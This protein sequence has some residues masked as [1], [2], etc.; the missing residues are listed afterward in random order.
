M[1]S[2]RYIN[3]K[4]RPFIYML[5]VF[6]FVFLFPATNLVNDFF[7]YENMVLDFKTSTNSV[8]LVICIYD[9]YVYI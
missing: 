8:N 7:I 1:L 4:P 9:I 6:L 3:P 5:V 2:E